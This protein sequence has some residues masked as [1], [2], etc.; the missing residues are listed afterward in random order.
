MA[1]PTSS[2]SAAAGNG[3]AKS[4]GGRKKHVAS[5]AG[6]ARYHKPIGSE[7]G[8]ARDDSHAAIQKDQG[9]RKNY[10]DLINGDQ[11]AQ[12]KTLD[13][14]STD[15]LNKLADISFSF[16]S[17]DPKV[18]ALRIA[19]RN[20]Q[21]RRG[22]KVPVGQTQ[23]YKKGAPAK[24]APTR[25]RVHAMNRDLAG[26]R[27]IE[28][29]NQR[30]E[31]D[32][33]AK[34][35]TTKSGSFPIN[36]PKQ[37]RDAQR[38]IGRAKP[39]QRPAV[40]RHIIARAQKL[41]CT[42]MIS[43]ATKHYARGH[44]APG[45]A[46]SMSRADRLAMIELV[47]H[48]KHGYIPLDAAALESK[49]KGGNGKR[50][51]SDGHGSGGVSGKLHGSPKSGSGGDRSVADARK[52][53]AAKIVPA[54]SPNPQARSGDSTGLTKVVKSGNPRTARGAKVDYSKMTDSQVR[55]AYLAAPKGSPEKAAHAVEQKRRFDAK[56]KTDIA[57]SQKRLQA[58]G[59]DA[60]GNK[61]PTG[62]M[63]TLKHKGGPAIPG[64]KRQIPMKKPDIPTPGDKQDT[65]G[66]SKLT[67][68][69][70]DPATRKPVGNKPVKVTAAQHKLLTDGAAHPNGEVH[71]K[72]GLQGESLANQGLTKK[73]GTKIHI[74][75]KGR[76]HV[77][78][79]AAPAAK[80]K[81]PAG[82]SAGSPA[83]LAGRYVQ[84]HGDA[85][86]RQKIAQLE[87]RKTLSARDKSLLAA[88]K[89][90]VGGGSGKA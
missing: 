17:S 22:I 1:A 61:L 78:N 27:L 48:W 73:T 76:A 55:S 15:D 7:I 67:F 23:T 51:W 37:V 12:R 56:A 11:A 84:M 21:S 79:N 87:A 60:H 38:A 26:V 35:G 13:G 3:T 47:G 36:S 41:N 6:A 9:A 43:D 19:A 75:D 29:V 20:A 80:A 81:K 52:A 14:M 58:L 71:V 2:S 34:R 62:T 30:A 39:E 10:G 57:N 42:H 63:E 50:W 5:A 45:T 8:G 85:G 49:M 24:A 54:H 18:V 64:T 82:A 44:A 69:A 53:R 89:S 46:I 28:L 65:T 16:K 59:I 32:K 83:E 31:A 40:A 68:Q 74:T 77:A 4:S 90:A 66:K 72:N 33:K 70:L 86:A 88:L 25:G